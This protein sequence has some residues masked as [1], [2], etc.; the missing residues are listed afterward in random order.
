MKG[1]GGAAPIIILISDGGPTDDYEKE[2]NELKKRGGFRAATKFAVAVGA[3]A[4]KDVLTKF[5]G[6]SEAVI[7]TEVVRLRLSTIIKKVVVTASKTRSQS[8][9]TAGNV[10]TTQKVVTEN[11]PDA[12][13]DDAKEVIENVT[14]SL[15]DESLF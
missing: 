11:G 12:N 7:D 9:S 10:D 13:D 6:F 1:R 3:D 15:D 4:D 5:A 14:A 8:V 2:L